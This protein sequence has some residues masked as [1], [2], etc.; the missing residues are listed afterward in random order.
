ML[1]KIFDRLLLDH[2]VAIFGR[3]YKYII[4]DP[5]LARTTNEESIINSWSY[6]MLA[7][8]QW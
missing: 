1:Q 4:R 5:R 7:L 2:E 8:V 3:M 6:H